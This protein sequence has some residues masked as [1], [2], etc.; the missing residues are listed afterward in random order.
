MTKWERSSWRTDAASTH[1]DGNIAD[2]LPVLLES[3]GLMLAPT[4]ALEREVAVENV[5]AFFKACDGVLRPPGPGTIVGTV[6]TDVI[7]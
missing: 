7:S 4:H 6:A 2:I 5:V 3:G 1:S